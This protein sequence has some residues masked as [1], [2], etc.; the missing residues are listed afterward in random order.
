MMERNSSTDEPPGRSLLED[1]GRLEMAFGVFCLLLSAVIA[2]WRHQWP[3]EGWLGTAVLVF[4]V[5]VVVWID[6]RTLPGRHVP[7]GR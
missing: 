2:G 7:A 1:R 4:V 5:Q 6:G 3:V